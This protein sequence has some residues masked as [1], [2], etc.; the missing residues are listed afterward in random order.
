M[1]ALLFLVIGYLG[2][3]VE[4]TLWFNW[5]NGYLHIDLA[6]ALINWYVLNAG[7]G[8]RL[9]SVTI[10]ALM[11]S[12]FSIL[13]FMAFLLAYVLAMWL[14]EY[15]RWN[16]LEMS[17]L[18]MHLF[19]FIASMEIEVLLLLWSGRLELFWP[20]GMVQSMSNLVLSPIVFSTMDGLASIGRVILGKEEDEG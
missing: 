1:K 6:P 10:F 4:S 18:H 16:M 2:L 5:T 7:P 12:F 19:T 14:V 17:R 3:V 9:L 11:S 8:R 13:P 15:M 20:Y